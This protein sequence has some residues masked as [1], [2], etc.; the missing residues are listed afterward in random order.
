MGFEVIDS[1][2]NSDLKSVASTSSIATTI[3]DIENVQY[4]K[5]R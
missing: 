4:G 5:P 2:Q 1:N 3:L